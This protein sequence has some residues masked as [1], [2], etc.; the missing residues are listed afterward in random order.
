MIGSSLASLSLAKV[1]GVKAN[2]RLS[3]GHLTPVSAEAFRPASTEALAPK[4]TPPVEH[5]VTPSASPD[6]I[7]TSSGTYG[8][9]SSPS[10]GLS[11]LPTPQ[12]LQIIQVHLEGPTLKDA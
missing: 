7:T 11:L 9:P 4:A 5:L 12:E 3:E 8:D 6:S 2:A 10:G 1:L